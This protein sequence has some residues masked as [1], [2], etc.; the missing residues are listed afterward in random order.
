MLVMVNKEMEIYYQNET[1]YVN[2]ENDITVDT[3][4]MLERRIFR[5]INDYAI[6]KIIIRILGKSNKELLNQFKRNY[7]HQF[8]GFLMI[9]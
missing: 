9:Q 6:D 2:V 7:Y 4:S 1:L 3:I 5:I 8:T